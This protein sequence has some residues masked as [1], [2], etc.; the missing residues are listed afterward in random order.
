VQVALIPVSNEKHIGKCKELQQFF[1]NNDIRVKL[2]NNDERVG[3]NIAVSQSAKDKYQIVIGD[4][5]LKGKNIKYRA[6]GSEKE[7]V[8]NLDEFLKLL[9]EQIASKK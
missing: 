7:V 2:Y 4:E 6:Y 9:K 3:K 8:S 1:L 5:E